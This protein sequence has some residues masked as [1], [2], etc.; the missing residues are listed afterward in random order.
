MKR[1]IS[2]ALVLLLMIGCMASCDLLNSAM[3][4]FEEKAESSLKVEEMLS[5]LSQKRIDDAKRLMHPSVSDTTALDGLAEYLN[6][7]TVTAMQLVGINIKSEVGTN[8][9][10]STEELSY[11]TT[12]SDGSIIYVS[13]V[14]VSNN[15]GVGFTSFSMSMGII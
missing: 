7:R 1:L 15:S 12:L 9:N 3:G 10:V 13:S 4:K 8:G 14:Y 5:A 6:G 2:L 11:K